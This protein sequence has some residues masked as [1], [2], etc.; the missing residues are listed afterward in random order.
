MTAARLGPD[1]ARWQVLIEPFTRHSEDL[2]ADLQGP[3]NLWPRR[4]SDDRIEMMV[5]STLTY[6]ATVDDER[7][8][9][10]YEQSRMDNWQF[11]LILNKRRLTARGK[12]QARRRP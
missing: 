9:L 8:L 12:G 5:D 3:L 10:V 11:M 1:G 6:T 7:M 2:L 4:K